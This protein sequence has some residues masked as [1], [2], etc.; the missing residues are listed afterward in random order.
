MGDTTRDLPHTDWT[1]AADWL[2]GHTGEDVDVATRDEKS[3]LIDGEVF[4]IG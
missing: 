1:A 3:V 2:L 4:Q